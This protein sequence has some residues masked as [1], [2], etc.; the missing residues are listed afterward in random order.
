MVTRKNSIDIID[1]LGVIAPLAFVLLI[2]AYHVSDSFIVITE[3]IRNVFW[4]ICI[5]MLFLSVFVYVIIV[6][7]N[8]IVKGI[9]KWVLIPYI[10]LQ[11][12]YQI[13]C[14]SGIYL[15][16]KQTWGAVF[17]AFIVLAFIVC[18]I[19]FKK[20]MY[21]GAFKKKMGRNIY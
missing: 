17:G 4:A 12:I 8:E 18:L 6:S 19:I 7:Y 2:A 13:S 16:S 14:F 11:L 9:Y 3:E 15:F 20:N 21:G 1:A 10:F 5:N